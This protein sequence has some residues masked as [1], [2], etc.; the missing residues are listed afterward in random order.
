MLWPRRRKTNGAPV[1]QNSCSFVLLDDFWFNIYSWT[2]T[3]NY[4]NWAV[5]SSIRI[6]L[7]YISRAQCDSCFGFFSCLQYRR[8]ILLLQ[9]YLARRF[10]FIAIFLVFLNLFLS[11]NTR[12]PLFLFSM[13]TQPIP[14]SFLEGSSRHGKMRFRQKYDGS[15]SLVAFYLHCCYSVLMT[16]TRGRKTWLK[17]WFETKFSKVTLSARGFLFSL[18][19]YGCCFFFI[20]NASTRR[21]AT[22]TKK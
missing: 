10:K 8:L 18:L 22:L 20:K 21:V 4:R 11:R 2:A 12:S 9:G 3:R 6:S 15:F 7:F 5:T 17:K 14:S 19:S 13:F 16:N 1:L